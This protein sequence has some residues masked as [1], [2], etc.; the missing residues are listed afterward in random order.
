MLADYDNNIKWFF[1]TRVKKRYV[2]LVVADYA[3]GG[4]SSKNVDTVFLN[5]KDDLFI[6][7]L[8]HLDFYLQIS[9]LRE[10]YIRKKENREYYT[11]FIYKFQVILLL[12]FNKLKKRFI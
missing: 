10:A 9:L 7:H 1:N 5:D 4:F 2:N 3:D 12:E 11:Y 8:Y 6:K